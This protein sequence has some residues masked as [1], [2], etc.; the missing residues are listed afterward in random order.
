MPGRKIPLVNNEL[1]H[2]FN[3][4]VASQP[5]F[6]SKR[7]YDRALE[8]IFY[9]QNSN[10]PIKYSRLLSLSVKD[11][12]GLLENIAKQKNFLVELISYCLMSNHFHFLLR[13]VKD[14]GIATFMSNF[15]N[16]YTRFF[17]TKQERT[18]PLFTGKFKSVRIET[19]E[20]LVHVS[21]YIH[22]NPYTS[23]VVK[24]LKDLEAYPYSS[25]PEF[26]GKV[27]SNFCAKEIIMG[28]YKNIESYKQ[29]VFDQADYQ[30][31]L[32]R[33][34]HLATEN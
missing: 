27:K 2:I 32:D 34:K 13:Q 23:F 9:Y 20:Q 12:A 24:T 28:N 4:G 18:G 8:T 31:S 11:R 1:Y 7:D 29:F 15:T 26:I 6:L 5:T 14:T 16:S 21:R 10:P 19:Q 3:R 33:I 25:F 17:N 22:L 30:R